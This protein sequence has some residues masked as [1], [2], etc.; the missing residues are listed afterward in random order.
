M[1][2]THT[3]FMFLILAMVVTAPAMA[4][5][6]SSA[7]QR[8]LRG[9]LEDYSR[10]AYPDHEQVEARR[11]EMRERMKKRLHEAD[12]DSDGTLSREEANQ[13]MPGLARHFDKIDRNGDGVISRE[14]MKEARQRMREMRDKQR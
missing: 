10:D 2:M 1:N 13:N 12:Q 11:H 6:R 3:K 7:D 8:S 9:D 4:E 5:S 14:E